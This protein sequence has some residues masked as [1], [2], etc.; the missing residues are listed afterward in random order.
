MSK[1]RSVFDM[2]RSASRREQV[3]YLASQL[4]AERGYHAVGMDDIG[5]AAGVSGPAIY[6]HFPSKAALLAALFNKLTDQLVARAAE[7]VAAHPDGVDAIRHLVRYQT[8]MCIY[9]RSVMAVY[10]SE[11]RSLP[12]EEQLALRLKQRAYLFDWMR[13]LGRVHPGYSEAELRALV[14]A[15]I[16]V[17]QSVVYYRSPLTE[18]DLIELVAKAAESVLQLSSQETAALA[19]VSSAAVD[20]G[21]A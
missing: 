10:L 7:I 12:Q 8:E 16:A 5:D 9:D 3:L 18:N 14:Q 2:S 21:Q 15:A 20:N 6:R 19:S 17:A 1:L 11:F 4:F 13:T